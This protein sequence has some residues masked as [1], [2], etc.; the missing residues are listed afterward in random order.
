MRPMGAFSKPLRLRKTKVAGFVWNRLREVPA[1]QGSSAAFR[2][3]MKDD[4]AAFDT[5][6]HVLHASRQ[7][8]RTIRPP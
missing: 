3:G 4:G 2:L 8:A 6:L 7:H 5:L 1:I